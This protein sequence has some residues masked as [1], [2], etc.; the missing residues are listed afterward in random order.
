MGLFDFFKKKDKEQE[1]STPLFDAFQ[2]YSTYLSIYINMQSQGNYAPIAAY[3][4]PNGELEGFLYAHGEDDSYFI[5]ATQTVENMKNHLEQ[6]LQQEAIKSYAIFYHSK[7]NRDDNHG[8]A[9]LQQDLKAISVVY[10]FE[11]EGKGAVALPY[12]FKQEE[13]TYAG[14]AN[15]SK[16]ENDS[17]FKVVLEQEKDYF[18]DKVEIKPPS[19]ENEIGLT[20]KQ[21]NTQTL[22]HTWGGLLGFENYEKGEVNAILEQ[23]SYLLYDKEPVWQQGA[24]AVS[25][26]KYQD[27]TF[28]AVN[29]QG[30]FIGLLP[31]IRTTYT[32]PFETKAIQEWEHV[33]Q[34]E[35]IVSGRGR[36]TFGLWFYATDYAENRKQ[37]HSQKN[38]E[39]HI[40]GIAFVVDAYQP[41]PSEGEEGPQFSEDFTAY[42]P[43]NN[44]PH[45]ACFDFIGELEAFRTTTLL[46]NNS[47][48]AHI[49]TVRLITNAEQK[50]FFTIDIYV[51][52]ENRRF[53]E[54]EVGMKLTGLFQM[55]G[56]IVE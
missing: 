16:E 34:L 29:Y 26:L 32:V 25:E 37:Y 3:E 4:K 17:L 43:S 23:H 40:S 39:V 52:P 56:R 31:I 30:S 44:L 38:L 5:P 9:T 53:E 6:Q 51:T 50:D 18:Q 49:L 1:K 14:I 21:S 54:L 22:Q 20:I 36:D 47:H 15:F 7:Y 10:H 35:A 45:H 12:V 27:V 33:H 19:Y 46:E 41:E 8:V 24:I 28:K 48:Q 13:I 42:M 2:P 55:Q 11:R